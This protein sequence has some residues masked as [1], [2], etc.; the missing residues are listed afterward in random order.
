M[1]AV[2]A[3]AGR[4][5]GV[6]AATARV[7][8]NKGYDI[9][10]NCLKSKEQAEDVVAECRDSG[11]R[12]EVFMGD[13]TQ[14]AICKDMANFVKEEW[15]RTDVLVNCIGVTK[16]ASYED[17]SALTEDDFTRILTGNITAPY[18]MAQAFQELMTKTGDACLINVSSAAGISGKGSSIAYAAAKGG[19]NTLT[20][21]LAK[22]LS[23][24]VRVNA[25]CPSFIDSSWWEESFAG[26][27]EKYA[28]L[29]KNM[30]SSN[31]VGKVLTPE[32]VARAIV[33]LI[34]SPMISGELLR[35]D[36]GAHI[37]QANP[38]DDRAPSQGR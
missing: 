37:G 27:E 28:T 32:D 7:L 16:G 8:A 20:L 14:S 4:K 18:L 1:L 35:L 11:V 34:E 33:Y 19:E 10:L 22:A 2:L 13:I 15:G 26:R 6:G 12:A 9:V 30:Q 25:V 31:L 17:L 38:R 21:A 3:G 24:E 29:I 23:P 5:R 36:G